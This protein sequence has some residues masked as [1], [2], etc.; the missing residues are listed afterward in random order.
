MKK[1]FFLL[2]LVLT[3]VGTMTMSSCNGCSKGADAPVINENEEVYHDYDGV[4]QDFTAGVS[5]IQ[6]THRQIMFSTL[7]V[8]E[9]QWRNSK[10]VFNDS[11]TAETID[12]LHVTDVIDVFY[13]WDNDKG[14][15]TQF[16]NTNVMKGTQIPYPVADIWIEDADLSEASIK[17]TAEQALIRL[18][19]VNYP[20]PPANGLSLRLPVGPKDCNPQYVIGTVYDVLFI[21]AMTGEVR[22]S[23]PAFF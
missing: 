14:P 16:I 9:Y 4:V 6:A 3:M 5:H 21:D 12:D 11:I 20:I 17:L 18:K 19:E 8:K 7:G 2:G 1:A 13:Y 23:N 22:N 10:I 15:Q